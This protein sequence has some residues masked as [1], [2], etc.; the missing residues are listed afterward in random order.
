MISRQDEFQ[1]KNDS[2][3]PRQAINCPSEETLGVEELSLS[4]EC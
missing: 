3:R 2:L 4:V 1:S